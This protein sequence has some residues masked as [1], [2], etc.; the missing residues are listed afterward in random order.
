MHRALVEFGA[1]HIGTLSASDFVERG[2]FFRMGVPPIA[3]DILPE[4]K[5]V[6]FD[7]AWKRRVRVKIDED[8]GLSVNFISRED[9]IVAKLAA[10]RPKDLGDVD[11]IR[12]ATKRK[13]KPPKRSTRTAK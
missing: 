2:K 3:V 9:L 6:A 12:A 8:A 13:R 4:I 7:A 11:A 1:P 10:G 5:G